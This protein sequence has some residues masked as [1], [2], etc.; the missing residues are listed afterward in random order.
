MAA[1]ISPGGE[2]GGMSKAPKVAI[3]KPGLSFEGMIRQ[4]AAWPKEQEPAGRSV[5]Y[6]LR[7]VGHLRWPRRRITDADDNW[8]RRASDTDGGGCVVNAVRTN[9]WYA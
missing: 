7:R 3:P 2:V 1:A 4:L 8:M 6:N 9:P 5:E